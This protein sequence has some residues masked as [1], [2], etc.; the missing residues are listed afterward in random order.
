VH[1]LVEPADEE[2]DLIRARRSPAHRARARRE[3]CHSDGVDEVAQVRRLP[4]EPVED[5]RLGAHEIAEPS[6]HRA[7]RGD[8]LESLEALF[9]RD[10]RRE[11]PREH[12]TGRA[13]PVG[14]AARRGVAA[15]DQA[16]ECA[17]LEQRDTHRG[18]EADVA[19]VLEV[20]GRD[21]AQHGERQIER[22]ARIRALRRHDGH[23]DPGAVRDDPQAVH[24]VE[25][26]RLLRDV[27]R[28]VVKPQEGL[29]VVAA[30][31]GDDLAVMVL[32]EAIDHHAVVASE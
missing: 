6:E 11:E 4:H 13:Y 10:L 31:L 24:E 3:D 30:G 2:P 22:A 9:G 28:R 23:G 8:V 32:V 16:P 14:H 19:H 7:P 5:L 15:R 21:R 20:N 26:A 25:R 27:R 12:L 29:E 17:L 18:A 1:V